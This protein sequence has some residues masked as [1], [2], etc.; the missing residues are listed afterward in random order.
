MVIGSK[1]P[2]CQQ[3]SVVVVVVVGVLFSANHTPE[4]HVT[5]SFRTTIQDGN[6]HPTS[7][8]S[9]QKHRLLKFFKQQEI[10]IL[11]D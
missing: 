10:L 9:R 6:I 2:H 1:Y 3:Y 11:R 8:F 7:I 5:F 4:A